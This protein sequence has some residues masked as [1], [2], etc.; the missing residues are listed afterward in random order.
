M[1]F[2]FRFSTLKIQRLGTDDVSTLP[3]GAKYAGLG[4]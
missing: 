3:R 4:L 2:N 1:I